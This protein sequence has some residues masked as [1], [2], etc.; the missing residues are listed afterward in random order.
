M[1]IKGDGAV[2]VVYIT[3]KDL[4]RKTSNQTWSLIKVSSV[5]N[6]S[7]FTVDTECV[8]DVFEIS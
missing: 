1:Y 7:A 6:W 8:D 3:Y 2:T 5:C 4:S